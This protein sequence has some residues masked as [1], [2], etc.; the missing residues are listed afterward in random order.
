[1]AGVLIAVLTGNL[2]YPTLSR[3]WLLIVKTTTLSL[4]MAVPG[5]IVFD[6][7]RWFAFMSLF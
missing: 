2:F 6:A 4:L 1:M 3:T 7:Y 5:Y